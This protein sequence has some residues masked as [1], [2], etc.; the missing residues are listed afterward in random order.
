MRG[1]AGDRG[2]GPAVEVYR[3]MQG[4]GEFR[5]TRSRKKG[6]RTIVSDHRACSGS[7]QRPGKSVSV[8]GIIGNLFSFFV[9]TRVEWKIG[10]AEVRHENHSAQNRP[11]TVSHQSS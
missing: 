1:E 11:D 6:R 5:S 4:F 8:L 2:I 3:V 9:K 10:L 7:H